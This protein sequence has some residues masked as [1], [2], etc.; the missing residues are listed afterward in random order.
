[1]AIHKRRWIQNRE[2][3]MKFILSYVME[4][5]Y[6]VGGLYDYEK[7]EEMPAQA[8]VNFMNLR[9]SLLPTFWTFLASVVCRRQ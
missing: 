4:H 3:K 2:V 7:E 1:M 5:G 6:A 8:G 9:Y